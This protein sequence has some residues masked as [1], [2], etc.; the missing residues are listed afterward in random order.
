MR[1]RRFTAALAAAVF[2]VTLLGGWGA[3][4]AFAQ[5]L[6]SISVDVGFPLI[7]LNDHK[8]NVLRR[9][10]SPESA[11]LVT[12]TAAYDRRVHELL[13]FGLG[14]SRVDMINFDGDFAFTAF[15]VPVPSLRGR[16]HLPHGFGITAAVV[17]SR[18]VLTDSMGNTMRGGMPAIWSLDYA[19]PRT[20]L[21]L[22]VGYST[23]LG[24][25]EF[26]TPQV[27]DL[28]RIRAGVQLRHAF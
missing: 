1:P 13:S 23:Q 16:L 17:P 15:A 4:S 9:A 28:K 5:Q 22:S 10:L 11:T 19:V 21:D 3:P 25:G 20:P 14:L 27:A 2:M 7:D 12:A 6:N 24:D 18:I 26:Q 8:D